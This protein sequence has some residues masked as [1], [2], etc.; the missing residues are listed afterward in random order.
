VKK[1]TIT[2]DSPFETFTWDEINNL[3]ISNGKNVYVHSTD[4]NKEV[5]S[6][7]LEGDFDGQVITNFILTQKHVILV[8]AHGRMEWINKYYPDLMEEEEIE[9]K[10]FYLDKFY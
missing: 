2:S 10:P 5:I 9:K 8:Y 4:V 3:Y 6:Y 1:S 7:D